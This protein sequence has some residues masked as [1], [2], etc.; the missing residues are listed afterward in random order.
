MPELVYSPNCLAIELLEIHDP[1]DA[2]PDYSVEAQRKITRNRQRLK[3]AK[4]PFTTQVMGLLATEDELMD[5]LDSSKA[6]RVTSTILLDIT[7]LPKRYFC[8]LLKRM[9]LLESYRNIIVTYTVPGPHG[10]AHGPLAEDPQPSDNLPG[11]AA[12]AIY[13]PKALVISVG[14]ESL[15]I[16]SLLEMYIDTK[17]ETKFILPFPP[18]G[19]A[20]RRVWDTL[21]RMDLQP[22]DI[23]RD[24]IESVASWDV[25]EVFKTLT[26][27]DGG[28]KSLVLA[29][30]GPKPHS[31][32]MALFA[33]KNNVGMYYTQPKSYNPDYS[34]G[35]GPTWAYIVKWDGV[36]CYDRQ[37]RVP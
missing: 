27:W 25:E 5:I 10:Y 21:R 12:P 1:T 28:S 26:H 2:Y 22:E 7:S 23:N 3:R 6:T 18:G 30:F 34:R 15:S 37:V 9:M 8:F 16:K 29:P 20:T 11:Y 4:I 14:F 24:N 31:L 35:R 13:K 36:P 19:G 32:A 33:L 17:R